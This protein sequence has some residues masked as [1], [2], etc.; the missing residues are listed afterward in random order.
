MIP[1]FNEAA[2]IPRGRHGRCYTIYGT[3]QRFNEAAGI[4]RGRLAASLG[5][6]RRTALLQ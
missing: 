5:Q 6:A 1:S 3:W 2:G 4:P